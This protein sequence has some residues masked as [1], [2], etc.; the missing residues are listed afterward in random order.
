LV[1]V[2]AELTVDPTVLLLA[3]LRVCGSAPNVDLCGDA[4]AIGSGNAARSWAGERW[5]EATR[6]GVAGC[7]RGKAGPAG[8]RAGLI[9]GTGGGLDGWKWVE[10]GESGIRV[11]IGEWA[12]A[13]AGMPANG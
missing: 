4:C 1:P 7:D 10:A 13:E 12:T 11:W 6:V 3:G 9:G 8:I 2:E 5:G